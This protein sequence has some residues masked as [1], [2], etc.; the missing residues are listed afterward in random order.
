M[1]S[2]NVEQVYLDKL[3]KTKL[4]MD[5]FTKHICD[6]LEVCE[7]YFIDSTEYSFNRGPAE[8]LIDQKAKLIT[9]LKQVRNIS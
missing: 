7:D 6:I 4:E 3:D 1:Y 9:I 5:K 2:A 8:Y